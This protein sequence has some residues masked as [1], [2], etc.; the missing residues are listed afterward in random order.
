MASLKRPPKFPPDEKNPVPAIS[1]KYPPLAKE[2][3]INKVGNAF[4]ITYKDNI[5]EKDVV[6]QL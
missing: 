2:E 4:V 3:L 6:Q 1:R 5:T